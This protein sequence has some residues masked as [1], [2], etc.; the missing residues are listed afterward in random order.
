MIAAAIIACEAAFW[1]LLL[2]GLTARYLLGRARL[3]AI[4][5][6]CVPLVDGVLLAVTAA[7]LADG[8]TAEWAH[9]LAALYLGFGIV[10]GPQVVRDLDRRFARRFADAPPPPPPRRPASRGR[11]AAEWR[12]WGRCVL[13]CLLAC[14]LLGALMLVAGDEQRTRALWS[15]GAWFKQLGAIC[16]LWLLFGPVWT[17]AGALTRRRVAGPAR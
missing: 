2:S 6:V 10:L 5:L 11:V 15:D 14:A 16:V 3:G 7:H 1:A 8:A 17:T 9:G 13:A 4:L 12:L